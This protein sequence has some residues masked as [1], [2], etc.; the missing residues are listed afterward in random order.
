MLVDRSARVWA[1]RP[2]DV[3]ASHALQQRADRREASPQA[4]VG[5]TMLEG[6]D[7]ARVID[8]V[9]VIPV[10]GP[11]MRSASFWMWSYEEVGRDLKLAQGNAAVRAIV[12]DIDS[13]GGLVAGCS[14]L[15]V[16]IRASGPK[17]VEAFVG[18]MAASAAYWLAAATGRIT[19]GSGAII[20][21]VGAVIEYVDMEPVLKKMG[22]QIVRVVAEQSPN[23][24]LDP[25]SAEGR[26]ELQALVDA[27]GAEFVANVAAHRG[28]SEADVLDRFGQGMIFDGAEAIRRSMADQKGTME[29]LIAELAGRDHGADA[30]PAAAA[31]E[32]PM[33]WAS[34]TLAALREHRADLVADIEA[35]IATTAGAEAAATERAR[36]LGLDEIAVAGH[37]AAVDAA[38]KDGKTT[39]GELALQI[40][41]AD[42]ASGSTYLAT[43]AAADPVA[44]VVMAPVVTRS[45]AQASGSIEDRAKATWDASADLQSEFAGNFAAYVAFEKAAASGQAR[46]LQRSN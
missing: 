41:R 15:A 34:L 6:S 25:D 22:A 8:G 10:M 14:D 2:D 5:G 4:Q 30:A 40:V 9:A 46:I 32:K 44:A 33:D 7:F 13:P 16:M 26:A 31:Q 19:L 42:K 29:S 18:G 1:L 23:K 28:V 24:R 45:T 20:G 11:L 39:P 38:K 43:R 37:E 3:V 21:S 35:A 36:I 17:P 12:L 27:S